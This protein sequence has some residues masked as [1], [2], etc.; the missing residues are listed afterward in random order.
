MWTLI[1][2]LWDHLMGY[3]FILF[4]AIQNTAAL[5]KAVHKTDKVDYK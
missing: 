4:D 3:M 1:V 5:L 2:E